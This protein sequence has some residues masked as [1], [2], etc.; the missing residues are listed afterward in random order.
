MRILLENLIVNGVDNCRRIVLLRQ[1][2]DSGKEEKT[3]GGK[4]NKDSK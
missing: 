2:L 4:S 1:I 3:D